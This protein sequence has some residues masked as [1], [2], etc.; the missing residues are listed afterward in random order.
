MSTD[1][2]IYGGVEDCLCKNCK[3]ISFISRHAVYFGRM[4]SPIGCNVLSYCE[5]YRQVATVYYV[6]NCS[7][8]LNAIPNYGISQDS[9][10][11]RTTVL[12][13]LELIL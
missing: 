3:L 4:F 12:C 1:F 7:L 5:R 6:F 2:I 13:L 9:D 11:L 8:S 10:D